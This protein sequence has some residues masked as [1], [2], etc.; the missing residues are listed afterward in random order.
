MMAEK[1]LKQ[2]P[3]MLA[4]IGLML[5]SG[6]ASAN[7]HRDSGGK[8]FADERAKLVGDWAG[9][10]LCTG[11]RPACHDEKVVYHISKSTN[12]PDQFTIAADKIVN[13]KAEEMYVLDFKYDRAKNTL[14]HE[15]TSGNLQGQWEYTIKGNTMEGAL[16]LL[17][18]KKITRRVKVTKVLK[19]K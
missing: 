3:L 2:R 6:A 9:E 8:L 14:I 4:L 15:F 13:G 16:I 19:D 1:L 17:P 18:D 7:K 10:S 11:V 5:V 12:G